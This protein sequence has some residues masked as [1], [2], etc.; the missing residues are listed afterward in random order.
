MPANTFSTSESQADRR[1]RL[2]N[3]S[4]RRCRQYQKEEQMLMQKEYERNEKQI[5]Q[6]EQRVVLLYRELGNNHG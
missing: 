3:E 2:K 5:K 1:R 4:A 6:L